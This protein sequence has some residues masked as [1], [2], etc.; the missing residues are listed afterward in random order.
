[1]VN[2]TPLKETIFNPAGPPADRDTTRGGESALLPP[3]AAQPASRPVHTSPPTTTKAQALPIATS[4]AKHHTGM[5]QRRAAN[6]VSSG[7]SLPLAWHQPKLH[8]VLQA[9]GMTGPYWPGRAACTRI[10]LGGMR[11]RRPLFS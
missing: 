10:L 9:G 1:M 2:R 3:D 6:V 8:H 4:Q 7:A 5:T 11:D